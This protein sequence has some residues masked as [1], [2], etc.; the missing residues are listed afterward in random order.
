MEKIYMCLKK[1]SKPLETLILVLAG[2]GIAS[3]TI[4]IFLQVIFRVII[5]RS[6][7]W[8]EEFSR[9]IEVWI[10]FLTSGYALGKGQHICMDLLIHVLPPNINFILEKI[11]AIIC[12]LFSTVCAV[13]SYQYMMAER[14]QM[15]ASANIPKAVV[16]V[17]LVLGFIFCIFYSLINLTRPKGVDP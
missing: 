9:Y 16:Y 1:V 12:I 15:F 13:F 6:L 3:I 10:V 17:S 11:N 14:M 5:G 4:I 8:S 7:S 2:A